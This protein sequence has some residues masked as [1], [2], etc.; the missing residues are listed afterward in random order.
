MRKLIALGL[1]ACA[2]ALE[3]VRGGLLAGAVALIGRES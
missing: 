2:D 1:W 3:V